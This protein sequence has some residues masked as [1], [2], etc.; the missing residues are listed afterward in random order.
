MVAM[1]RPAYGRHIGEPA[2]IAF[3][4]RLCA[5]SPQFAAMWARQDLAVGE[6]YVKRIRHA[7][8][9]ELRLLATHMAL[10]VPETK[11][12]VY[13]P[14]DEETRAAIGHLRTVPRPRVGCPQ[15]GFVRYRNPA[16]GKPAEAGAGT[17]LGTDPVRS[18]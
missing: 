7:E 3:V 5:A 4:E 15:H 16:L 17:D 6:P 13:T 14:A 1:L 2:W 11:L 8:V 12:N 18:R 10:D 9:G